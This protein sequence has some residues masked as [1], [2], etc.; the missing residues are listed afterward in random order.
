MLRRALPIA[1]LLLALAACGDDGGDAADASHA[2]DADTRG[3]IS[4]SWT[5]SDGSGPVTCED[6]GANAVAITMLPVGVLGS[7]TDIAS[8]SSGTLTTGPVRARDYNLEITISSVEGDLIDAPITLR[9]VTVNTNQDTQLD[10]VEFVVDPIGN[11]KFQLAANET[12]GNCD[13]VA[14]GG[15]EIVKFALELSQDSTCVPVDFAIADENGDP[16]APGYTVSCTGE[17][18]DMCLPEN[19]TLSVTDVGSGPTNLGII[20]YRAGDEP[21]YMST[22]NLRIPGHGLTADIGAI[23]IPLDLTNEVCNPPMP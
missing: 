12:G 22:A 10:P 18:Y 11:L 5:I 14:N 15:A 2:P 19:Y 9:N 21:C 23:T 13:T 1:T 17:T 8:C 6:I 16:V 7:S 3:T 4:F 20:G